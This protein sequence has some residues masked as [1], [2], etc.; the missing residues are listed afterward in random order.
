MSVDYGFCLPEFPWIVGREMAG[1]V[2][3]VG[4]EV[5][6]LQV[7]DRVWTSEYMLLSGLHGKLISCRHILQRQTSGLLPASCHRS[8][9]YSPSYV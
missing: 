8:R 1:V 7:G 9:T 4:R 6:G 2:E 5:E 3:E